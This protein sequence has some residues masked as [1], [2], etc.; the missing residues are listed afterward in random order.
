MLRCKKHSS[1]ALQQQS[2]ISK[3]QS[4][5]GGRRLEFLGEEGRLQGES[6]AVV[7][8]V[9]VRGSRRCGC[10]LGVLRF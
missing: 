2:A 5:P 8:D 10:G 6:H 7:A 1:M 3:S 4:Q 9:G